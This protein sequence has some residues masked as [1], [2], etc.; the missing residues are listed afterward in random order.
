MDGLVRDRE[1]MVVRA[2]TGR[3]VSQRTHPN[4]AMIDV[5]LS[6]IEKDNNTIDNCGRLCRVTLDA[7]GM[8]QIALPMKQCRQSEQGDRSKNIVDVSVWNWK[9][10]ALEVSKEVSAWISG[11]LKTPAKIIRYSGGYLTMTEGVHAQNDTNNDDDEHRRFVDT[12]WAPPGN[13]IAFPDGFPFLLTTQKSLDELNSKIDR[14]IGMERFRTNFCIGGGPDTPWQ[15]DNWRRVKLGSR[16][17]FDV[18]KPCT[19]C[20]IPSIDPNSGEEGQEPQRILSQLRK[21]E[22]IGYN[23]P[24]SFRQSVF[25]GVNMTMCAQNDNNDTVVSI[26]DGVSIIESVEHGEFMMRPAIST[27]GGTCT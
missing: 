3:F 26:G 19:R 14:A 11:Y 27:G 9:G 21:G 13:E 4:M 17:V 5:R 6:S 22:I 12:N 1:Y 15:E 2:D 25:F 16:A 8:P 10:K 23:N 7:P 18:L 24:S 20:K